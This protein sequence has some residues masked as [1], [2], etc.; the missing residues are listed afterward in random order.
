MIGCAE[1]EAAFLGACLLAPMRAATA[2]TDVVEDDFVDPRHRVVFAAMVE[3]VERGIPTDPVTVLG[4]L[5]RTG[6]GSPFTA[7]RNPG[8][9]LADLAAAA[10]LPACVQHYRTVVLEHAL[11]RRAHEAGERL[12]QAAEGGNP[13]VLLDVLDGDRHAVLAVARRLRV[14]LRVVER[15]GTA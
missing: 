11:L 5:R 4:H 12:Q 2:L 1:A 15:E 3:L 8:V 13:E 6:Q 9:F 10:P 14:P 7:N